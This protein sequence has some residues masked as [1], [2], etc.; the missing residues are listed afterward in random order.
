MSGYPC[1]DQIGRSQDT[2]QWAPGRP[3]AQVFQPVYFWNN[4]I[5]GSEFDI[6]NSGL[7]TW[8]RQDRDWY[9]TN[10]AFNG[11]AGVGS[12]PIASRPST[13]TTGVA[14]W[15]TNEGEWNSLQAGPD[16]RLYKCTATN[17]WSLYYTPY[18]YPHPWQGSG[19]APE[20]P[21]PPSNL[22]ITTTSA[23]LWLLPATLGLRLL[24]RRRTGRD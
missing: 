3:Y 16:G 23:L 18:P 11:T 14:Y 21:G 7:N 20:A 4:L 8:I 13:C 17:T 15:A 10:S 6:D 22:R 24:G 1:R 5:N 2:T 12:G 9:T 19:T